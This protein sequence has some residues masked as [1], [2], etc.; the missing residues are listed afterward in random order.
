MTRM[1]SNP[2]DLGRPVMKSKLISSHTFSG[3]GNGCSNPPGAV[4]KY[5]VFGKCHIPSQ[6]ASRLSSFPSNIGCSLH[7]CMFYGILNVQLEGKNAS[8]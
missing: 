8:P 6:I 2:F 3:I 4:A 1:A 7:A 5:S